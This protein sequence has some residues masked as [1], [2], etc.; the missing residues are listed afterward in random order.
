MAVRSRCRTSALG[1]SATVGG[2]LIAE[3]HHRPLQPPTHGSLQ[4]QVPA[5]FVVGG[6]A[7]VQTA[8]ASPESLE[9]LR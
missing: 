1:R 3:V 6:L 7:T 8:H 9:T 5:T 4:D 2:R